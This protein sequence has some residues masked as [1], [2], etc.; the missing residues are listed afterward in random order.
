MMSFPVLETRSASSPDFDFAPAFRTS[1]G[2]DRGTI[3]PRPVDL[4]DRLLELPVEHGPVH[5]RDD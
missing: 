4:P 1:S 2:L 3:F 5:D